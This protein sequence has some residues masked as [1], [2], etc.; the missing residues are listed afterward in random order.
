MCISYEIDL[1]YKNESLNV[2]LSANYKNIGTDCPNSFLYI[3]K[4]DEKI[5]EEVSQTQQFC[6]ICLFRF[7]R[8]MGMMTF[9]VMDGILLLINLI[10]I[11]IHSKFSKFSCND[12]VQWIHN[13]V[14][15]VCEGSV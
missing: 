3:L 4:A 2:L 7:F 9:R 1:K 15:C 5:L 8:L 10:Q 14:E 6:F 12:F 11:H 13:I